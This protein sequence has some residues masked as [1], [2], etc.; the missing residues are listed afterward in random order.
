MKK[1]KYICAQPRLLY[2]AWQ[3]E[4]MINNFLKLGISPSDINILVGYSHEDSTTSK[5]NTGPWE[6]LAKH[7]VDVNFF[8]YADTRER[9]VKYI[10]SIRP[11]ILKQHFLVYPELKNDV[12][13]YHD[14]DIVFTKKPEFEKYMN[15]DI[16]YLSDTNSYLNYD[17]IVSKGIDIYNTMC[18][19]VEIHPTIPKLM[20][21]DSGGA[22][23]IMKNLDYNYW[24]KVEKDADKLYETINSMSNIKKITN[25]TYHEL[26]IWCADMWAVL[27]NA[28]KNGNM[29][30]V[31]RG[32]DFCW[33][34]DSILR[35]DSTSIYHNSGVIN[36][37]DGLFYK[38]NYMNTLPY[39]LKLNNFRKD[40]C[41]YNYLSEIIYTSKITCL[42]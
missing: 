42:K 10:P 34:I 17:Y 33:S 9:P 4:V 11:N 30:K 36:G 21:A 28:W 25:P 20:N 38:A 5:D 3:V 16:W 31:D 40:F 26:Q 6:K 19:I 27:W 32:L 24:D 23:Y 22:Q 14:C 15:D 13:F 41:S 1:L 8:F 12:F 37:N 2:Y 18:E 7:Y 29:T 39:N 35:W